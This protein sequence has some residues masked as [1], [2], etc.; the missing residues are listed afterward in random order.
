M[1]PEAGWKQVRLQACGG[2][3]D[4]TGNLCTTVMWMGSSR[5]PVEGI[6]QS[7]RFLSKGTLQTKQCLGILI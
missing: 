5:F 3:K 7:G 1:Q 2:L 6:T 4:R